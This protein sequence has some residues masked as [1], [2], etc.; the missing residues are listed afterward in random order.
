MTQPSV[1]MTFDTSLVDTQN[2]NISFSTTE[3]DPSE[4]GVLTTSKTLNQLDATPIPPLETSTPVQHIPTQDAYD[5]WASVYDTDGNMLQAIDDVELS[6]LLPEFLYLVSTFSSNTTPPSIPDGK[7]ELIELG[8]GTGRTTAKVLRYPWD[9]DVHIWALDFSAGMLDIA[10][11]KLSPA[12]EGKNNVSLKVQQ[13]ECFPTVQNPFSS[14]VP[15]LRLSSEV[16]HAVDGLVSTLVLEHI[17]LRDYFATLS[18][19]VRSGGYALVTNMHSEMGSISQAGFVNQEGVKI[20]GESFAHTP[21]ET[22]D[23]ARRAG[24]EVVSVKEREMTSED[25]ESGKVG[26]RGWKWVGIKVWYGVVLR[27]L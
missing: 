22:V 15:T 1:N 18:S 13:T 16:L 6:T 2:P 8:C 14:P 23:A 11:Q 10:Q 20:R 21:A 26:E 19:L 12:V 27:R 17:P 7:T 3:S 5:Q 4:A 25:V 24:F 9:R